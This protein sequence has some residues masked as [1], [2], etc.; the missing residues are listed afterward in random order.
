[1]S[2]T[3]SRRRAVGLLGAVP[4]L[5]TLAAASNATATT[6]DS[7]ALLAFKKAIR[8]KYDMKEAA[9]AAHDAAII[10]NNFYAADVVSTGEGEGVALNRSQLMPLYEEVVK[11]NIV[12][13]ES[14]YT[15]V[16]GDTG[17]DWADFHVT[18]TNGKDKPFSFRIIF[19]WALENNEWMCKGDMYFKGSFKDKS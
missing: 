18:P 3:F 6:S 11:D 19:L 4:A 15:Y 16:N 1:M 10:V 14:F 13:V 8:A 12:K 17:W 9:F 5:A 7:G 2:I